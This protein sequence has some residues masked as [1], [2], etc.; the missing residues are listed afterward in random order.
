MT[1]GSGGRT[2]CH[3]YAMTVHQNTGGTECE[4]LPIMFNKCPL[5]T[6]WLNSTFSRTKP[7]D[8]MVRPALITC[9]ILNMEAENLYDISNPIQFILFDECIREN[10]PLIWMGGV[11]ATIRDSLHLYVCDKYWSWWNNLHF[12]PS[13]FL[14]EHNALIMPKIPHCD[15]WNF[16]KCT[17]NDWIWHS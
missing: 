6:D 5:R 1:H 12:H 16:H 9:Q 13:I 11:V 7:R 15:L 2:M 10:D 14:L 17:R 8:R 3:T 4:S